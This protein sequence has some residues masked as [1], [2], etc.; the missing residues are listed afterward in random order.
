MKPTDVVVFKGSF[1]VYKG[2]VEWSVVRPSGA[3]LGLTNL[4]QTQLCGSLSLDEALQPLSSDC[5][6]FTASTFNVLIQSHCSYQRC[7]QPLKAV[8]L[9]Q[10]TEQQTDKVC[11]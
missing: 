11:N 1:V 2:S 10:S 9:S 7:F 4:Q 3:R 6:H 8:V 5:F